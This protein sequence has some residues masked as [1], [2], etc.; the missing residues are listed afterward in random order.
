MSYSLTCFV[1]PVRRSFFCFAKGL[2]GLTD[3]LAMGRA[4]LRGEEIAIDFS[5]WSL[6]NMKIIFQKYITAEDD[7]QVLFSFE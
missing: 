7:S 6:W 4:E 1:E 5:M 3:G 2:A